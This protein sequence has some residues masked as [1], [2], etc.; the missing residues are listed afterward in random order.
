MNKL[1]SVP[2]LLEL[3]KRIGL[4]DAAISEM[5][6]FNNTLL[7]RW[8]NGKRVREVEGED[9]VILARAIIQFSDTALSETVRLRRAL[10]FY[11]DDKR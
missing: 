11:E 6:G 5:T 2:E 1:P 3:S 4:T 9:R 8:R 10:T 7:S